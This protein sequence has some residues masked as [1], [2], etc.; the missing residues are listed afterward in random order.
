MYNIHLRQAKAGPFFDYCA[1]VYVPVFLFQPKLNKTVNKR[2][3]ARERNYG[4][5]NN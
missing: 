3:H 4:R 1:F 2:Q 5:G